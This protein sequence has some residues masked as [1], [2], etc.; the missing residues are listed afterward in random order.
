[1]TKT[2]KSKSQQLSLVIELANGKKKWIAFEPHII[3]NLGVWGS[4]YQTEDIEEQEAL[5]K[6]EWYNS[7][8]LPRFYC[9][10]K[11]IDI[12]TNDSNPD[13]GVKTTTPK[14]KR[15]NANTKG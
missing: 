2:Y 3:N 5:E 6:H 8:K 10:E 1:M 15:K 7:N 12:E 11:E 14:R 13:K 4:V 9:E